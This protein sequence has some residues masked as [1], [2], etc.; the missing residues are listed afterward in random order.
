MNRQEILAKMQKL[1]DFR[2]AETDP[3]LR[4][5]LTNAIREYAASNEFRNIPEEA[6]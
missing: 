4:E 1:M 6:A 5:I 3:T 2:D